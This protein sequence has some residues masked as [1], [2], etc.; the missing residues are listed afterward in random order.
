MFCVVLLAVELDPFTV[1]L[2]K[3]YRVDRRVSIFRQKVYFTKNQDETDSRFIGTLA[4]FTKQKT[5]EIPF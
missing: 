4:V 3:F 1:L 2:Q 5:W